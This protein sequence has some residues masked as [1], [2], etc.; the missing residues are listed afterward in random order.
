MF[1][2]QVI[3]TTSDVD[4]DVF[5]KAVQGLVKVCFPQ[6]VLEE[7]GIEV[8][9]Q[10]MRSEDAPEENITKMKEIFRSE[11]IHR[12]TWMLA[13]YLD[14]PAKVEASVK[15]IMAASASLHGAKIGEDVL[16]DVTMSLDAL[17]ENLPDNSTEQLANSTDMETVSFRVAVTDTTD[18]DAER[19]TQ[20]NE[21]EP[22]RP[23]VHNA[24]SSPEEDH[25]PALPAKKNKKKGKAGLEPKEPVKH[26]RAGKESKISTSWRWNV[27]D[28]ANIDDM[29]VHFTRTSDLFAYHALPIV[30]QRLGPQAKRKQ[31]RQKIETMLATM[32]DDEFQKW[33]ESFHKL[34]S[35]DTTMLERFSPD[36]SASDNC[37]VS[38]MSILVVARKHVMQTTETIT[39]HGQNTGLGGTQ[40]SDK[41]VIKRERITSGGSAVANPLAPLHAAESQLKANV[42]RHSDITVS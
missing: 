42:S 29:S 3:S 28:S 7:I 25:Q 31:L 35:G 32:P 17:R 1:R 37:I 14:T 10:H 26:M 20:S 12:V 15:A 38:A 11:M 27:S 13:E 34:E 9:T 4:T 22:D 36:P 39:P 40:T 16:G 2:I 6:D 19:L 23:V 33:V 5:K 21:A 24:D 41:I 18:N 30:K 8:V